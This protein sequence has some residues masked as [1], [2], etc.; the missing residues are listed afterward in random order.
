MPTIA[1]HDRHYPTQYPTPLHRN[2]NLPLPTTI[3]HHHYIHPHDKRTSKTKRNKIKQTQTTNTQKTRI[4]NS[5][6]NSDNTRS[7]HN[8][9]SKQYKKQ[10][11]YKNQEA[12]CNRTTRLP[13]LSPESRAYIQFKTSCMEPSPF[14]V[15][16]RTHYTQCKNIKQH[17]IIKHIKSHQ[18]TRS[19]KTSNKN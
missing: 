4:N 16:I 11:Q 17:E 15:N 19:S 1:N 3:Y 8:T 5:N 9:R 10:S 2:D 12:C 13:Q 18:K 14:L 6:R 7:N